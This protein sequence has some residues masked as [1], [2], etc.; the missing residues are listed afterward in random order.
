MIEEN[1]MKKNI[2]I[3]LVLI[4]FVS[5]INCNNKYVTYIPHKISQLG[6]HLLVYSIAKWVS[7]KYK[8]PLLYQPFPFSNSFIFHDKE[9][10]DKFLLEKYKNIRLGHF[11]HNSFNKEGLYATSINRSHD[12]HWNDYNNLIDE[13]T[14]KQ[15]SIS[16]NPKITNE[17]VIDNAFVSPKVT[18]EKILYEGRLKR[19]YFDYLFIASRKNPNFLTELRKLISS[20]QKIIYL[21]LPKNKISVAIHIR[22]NGKFENIPQF[23]NCIALKF[24]PLDFYTDQLKRLSTLL[25][26]IPLFIYI[27]TNHSDPL[28]LVQEMKNNLT[29]FNNITFACRDKNNQKDTLIEDLFLMSKFDCLIRS[30]SSFSMAAQLIGN[31]KIVIYP[32]RGIWKNQ[33]LYIDKIG[34]IMIDQNLN[35]ITPH[36]PLQIKPFIKWLITS[37]NVRTIL[38]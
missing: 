16:V 7:W 5:S 23:S 1:Y 13:F 28:S 20:K 37:K 27:F 18:D 29:Q 2:K 8:I 22:M 26:N 11:S 12:I 9:Y 34:M 31:H 15:Y 17:N 4:F 21:D 24:P 19:G 3:V 35:F 33:T 25:D 6:D 30:G 36:M 14:I 38:K 32:K 10:F